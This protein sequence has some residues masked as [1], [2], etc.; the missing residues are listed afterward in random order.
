MMTDAPMP[1]PIVH[2]GDG[3]H[4]LPEV[5]QVDE[6]EREPPWA[7]LGH[8]IICYLGTR[9]H[10]KTLSMVIDTLID[11][12]AA[13]EHRPIVSNVALTVDVDWKPLEYPEVIKTA[14]KKTTVKMMPWM[15]LW[16]YLMI[17]DEPYTGSDAR[18]ASS[19][20][21]IL[22]SYFFN[23]ARKRGV[24]LRMGLQRFEDID[25]RLRLHTDYLVDCQKVFKSGMFQVRQAIWQ[26]PFRRHDPPIMRRYLP[27]QEGVLG[28]Y[29]PRQVVQPG[30]DEMDELLAST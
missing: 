30:Q 8:Y 9:G 18:R 26:A 17:W 19:D 12:A 13:D 22:V 25:P 29:D 14:G 21:N 28:Y 27:L 4:A 20:Q 15:T 6:P 11:H 10:G 5:R 16:D 24:A 1:A 7:G 23:Q 2:S 3:G